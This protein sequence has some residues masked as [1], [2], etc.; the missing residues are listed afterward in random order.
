MRSLTL[1]SLLL[2]ATLTDLQGQSAE[3][4]QQ[5]AAEIF[6][7]STASSEREPDFS[8]LTDNLIQL[9]QNPININKAGREDLERIFFLSDSQIEALLF[10]RYQ[11]K[12]FYSIYE[13]Q[14]IEGFSR[15][16]LEW[17]EPMITFGISE[18]LAPA[19]FRAKG[20]LFIRAQT[21]L[22][23]QAGYRQREDGTT[24]YQG[25]KMKLYTRLEIQPARDLKMGLIGEKDQ[26]EPMFNHQISTL[27]H[28][29]A[30]LA[31]Q[32][33]KFLKQIIVGQYRMSGG[34]G[35]A[36]QT[37]MAPIKSSA[38]T[39]IRNRQASFRPSLSAS[40]QGGLNG[41]LMA[42][43]TNDFAITPFLSV[44]NVDGRLDTLEN[45]STFITSLKT[46]GYHRTLTELGQRKNVREA[47][48]GLQAK[49]HLNRFILETGYLYYHLNYPVRPPSEAYQ[50]NYFSGKSSQNYWVA[51][52]G[53]LYNIHLFS[54]LAFNQTWEPALWTGIL[55]PVKGIFDWSVGYRRIPM[56][57]KAPL[58]APLTEASV[59]AGESGLYTG[60][61]MDLPA[62]FTLS[63]YL[64]YY[65]H[66]W[67]RY[68]TNAPANGYD[69]LVLLSHDAIKNWENTLRYRYR[70]KPINLTTDS[71]AA[72]V[73]SRNQNQWR[74]QSR[75]RAAANWTFTLRADIQTVDRPDKQDLPKGFY[76]GQDIRY[77]SNNK[78]WNL[79]TRY[80]IFNA[81]EFDTRVYAYEPD[82]LYS[83]STPAYYGR[84][85][86][87]LI[88]GK[89]TIL[90]KLDLWARYA[91]WQ[92]SNRE[93][94]GTGFTLIEGNR[95][96]EIKFQI[97]KRF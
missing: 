52:E 45:G 7:N 90:P 70:N 24:P 10:Q 49:Y 55:M 2:M 39:S 68:Q 47:V 96:R 58:G 17:L 63:A 73:G 21:L 37:G 89:W 5:L 16:T 25:H 82:V 1:L 57:Y 67:L 93:N 94:I 42:F 27:D 43:E 46:D 38:T 11:L 23:T 91:Q 9:Y 92:Y 56:T 85:S 62:S 12:T 8:S 76:M 51:A 20:D 64:D 50:R 77:V 59:P 15:Q 41:L 48:Y 53:S 30:Y 81:E 79:T 65:R 4:I 84:G 26:G 88:M 13:M 28:L 34:Q 75:Y 33:D 97:R 19:Q 87:W 18:Q 32:P 22:E 60:L 31:W 83:F 74:F 14:S 29:A 72:P 95:S 80:A 6:E 3:Q 40:E 35:L 71:Q 54:E 66:N 69:F 86:R 78:K 61:H 44:K 36:L